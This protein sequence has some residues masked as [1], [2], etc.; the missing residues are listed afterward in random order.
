MFSFLL[1]I[2]YLSFISLGLPDALLG[3]G[4]P[5]MVEEL[6]SPLSYAGIISMII[7]CGT[8]VSS[9]F[10][11]KLTSRLG[12]GRVTAISVMLTALALFG[13]SISGSFWILCVLA[14]PYG[15]GA[16]AV[17]AALNNY[18]A[19][20][21]KASHMSWLHCFWGVG[22]SLG[23]YIME[24]AITKNNSWREGYGIVSGIQLGI[25]FLLLSSLSYW[26]KAE[27]K[28]TGNDDSARIGI[29]SAMKI[30]GVR[31]ILLAFFGY[32]AFESTTG[33]WA[34]SYLAEYKGVGAE[35]A[36]G[37]ASLFYLGI[38]LGRFIG[39]FISDR[40]GDK[41]MIRLGEGIILAG[42]LLVILPISGYIHTLTGLFLAGL[43]AAPVYPSI[44]H[45]TPENFGKEN[46]AKIV[47]MQMASAYTGS[48]LIPPLF[49]IM[50]EK[51]NIS[52]YPVFLLIFVMLL[53]VMT[54]K[55][56]RETVG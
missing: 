3:A 23:P 38:T 50:A 51:I 16:G 9:L 29:K 32:C 33:L 6:G 14:V 55:V 13:F 39:G 41:K 2:I 31:S 27:C 4:W 11:D 46:S 19:L 20:H 7:S 26:K 24:Y 28:D 12:T 43:G 34:S 5:S 35:L 25:T 22:A 36:A 52:I 49:G 53:V 40:M 47:G 44:I 15:L 42:I 48:T 17:D 18:V 21:Y 45:S 56:N 37:F 54:E 1:A 10:S 30:R 8:I